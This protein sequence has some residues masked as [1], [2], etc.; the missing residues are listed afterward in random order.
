[1][2][3]NAFTALSTPLA[4]SAIVRGEAVDDAE[5]AQVGAV[6]LWIDLSQCSVCRKGLPAT[7]SGT[8][9]APDLVL[10]ASH[11]IE[12]PQALNG[13]LDRVVFSSDMF[14]KDAPVSKIKAIKTAADYG[15]KGESGGDLVLIKLATPAPAPWRPVELPLGLLPAKAEQ[16]EAKKKES[17]FYPDGLGLRSWLTVPCALSEDATPSAGLVPPRAQAAPAGPRAP[18]EPLGSVLRFPAARLRPPPS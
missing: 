18:A 11:C 14:N 16:E 13:T 15:L 10:S 1:V 6:G 2:L 4:A 8:L 3:A 12:F 17:P 5:A 9:I 7:C